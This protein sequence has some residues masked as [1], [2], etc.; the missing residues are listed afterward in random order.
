MTALAA[1]SLACLAAGPAQAQY[2][3][4]CYSAFYYN[5][6]AHDE[7]VGFAAGACDYYGPTDVLLEGYRTNYATYEQN[8]W[9]YEGVMYPL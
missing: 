7:Q 9:C 1:I 5:N 4:P 3:Q 8:G 2:Y 6:A